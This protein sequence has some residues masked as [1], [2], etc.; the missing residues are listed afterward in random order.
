MQRRHGLFSTGPQEPGYRMRPRRIRSRKAPP[1]PMRIISAF[2]TDPMQCSADGFVSAFLVAR[3]GMKEYIEQGHSMEAVLSLDARVVNGV[4]AADNIAALNIELNLLEEQT[5][6][7]RE[8][9][10]F[11]SNRGRGVQRANAR[12]TW[13]GVIGHMCAIEGLRP[14][15][16]CC[17]GGVV[18]PEKP[19]SVPVGKRSNCRGAQFAI[20][21]GCGV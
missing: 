14:V 15:V 20:R 16:I 17:R 19:N 6:R 2:M 18:D 11:E 5:E 12:R 4:A 10:E 1:R 3:V 21:R 9:I 13:C 7:R 8:E